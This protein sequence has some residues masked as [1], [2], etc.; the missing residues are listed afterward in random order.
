MKNILEGQKAYIVLVTVVVASFVGFVG[1]NMLSGTSSANN[2]TH[3][4]IFGLVVLVVVILVPL[5]LWFGL[6]S[7]KKWAFILVVIFSAYGAY[8]FFSEPNFS[9][10]NIVMGLWNIAALGFAIIVLWIWYKE[11]RTVK[12]KK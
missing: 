8:S 11:K 12:K 5:G 10:T 9:A 4:N 2:F 1:Y 7:D 3:A 6:E